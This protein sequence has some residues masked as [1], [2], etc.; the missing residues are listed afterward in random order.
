MGKFRRNLTNGSL[1]LEGLYSDIER[2]DLFGNQS[3]FQ[4]KVLGKVL[5]STEN[6]LIRGRIEEPRMAHQFFLSDPCD[7]STAA[8]PQ[9]NLALQNLHTMITI[10]SADAAMESFDEGDIIIVALK[11]GENGDKYDLQNAKFISVYEKK[12]TA[13]GTTPNCVSLSNVSFDG[14]T[15]AQFSG[16]LGENQALNYQSASR[17]PDEITQ[18]IIH[19]TAGHTGAG[20]AQSTINR[21]AGKTSTGVVTIGYTL[22]SGTGNYTGDPIEDPTC[23]QYKDLTGLSLGTDGHGLVCNTSRSSPIDGT[24]I[25]EDEV[26]TSIHYAVDQGGAIVQGVLDK[27]VAFHAGSTTN[28]RSIG[29]ETTGNPTLVAGASKGAGNI[30]HEMY[31]ETLLNTL[32]KLVAELCTK[33]N[34]PT[35]WVEGL[36]PTEPGI[37]G[38]EQISSDRYDPGARQDAEYGARTGRGKTLSGDDGTG[39]YWDWVDF[40]NRVRTFTGETTIIEQDDAAAA[41]G[42]P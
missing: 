16:E 36:S 4:V 21:F 34:I 32:A 35:V 3:Q 8:N 40:I 33:Y 1:W 12:T 31:T 18:I 24:G 41:L 13:P 29:I 17:G 28:K 27:D 19:S 6:I 11:P 42:M 14:G 7:S 22:E 23:Q 5:T 10:K 25:V 15:Q 37:V 38:H 26:S 30:Y 39:R 2:F 9:R 20:K